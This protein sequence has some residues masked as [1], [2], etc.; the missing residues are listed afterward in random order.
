[1]LGIRGHHE[2]MSNNELLWWQAYSAVRPLEPQRVDLMESRF[3]GV[4]ASK[5]PQEVVIDWFDKKHDPE[6]RK[7]RDLE[8][9][10]ELEELEAKRKEN[11]ETN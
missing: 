11:G 6:W 8:W 2:S 9:K 3:V 7:Q 4:M 1:L 5:A 10:R